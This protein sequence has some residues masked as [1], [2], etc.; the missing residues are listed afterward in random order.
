MSIANNIKYLRESHDLT[1]TE[2]A[3]LFGVTDKAVSTWEIGTRT[4]RMGVIQKI[5]DYF[6]IAKSDILEDNYNP[7]NLT[8]L[9]EETIK[10][11]YGEQSMQALELFARLDTLDQGR[12]IGNMEEMLKAEKYSISKE[13]SNKKAM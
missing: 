9:F 6:H 12:T 4:P 7:H 8:P 13:L 1:Q 10:E 11:E 2:F 5:A 3:D